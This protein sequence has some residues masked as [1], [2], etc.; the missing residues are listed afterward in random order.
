MSDSIATAAVRKDDD[1]PAN[2]QP[3]ALAK[4]VAIR[5]PADSGQLASAATEAGFVVEVQWDG[6]V[7]ASARTG[8]EV[9][10][11][12]HEAGVGAGFFDAVSSEEAQELEATFARLWDERNSLGAGLRVLHQFGAVIV[13]KE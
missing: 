9:L 8:V 13:R 12:L 11:Y 5:L 4:R 1:R 2:E 3:T 10:T 6:E 7:D